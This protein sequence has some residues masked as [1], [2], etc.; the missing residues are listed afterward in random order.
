[1]EGRGLAE[2]ATVGLRERQKQQRR[3]AIMESARSLFERVGIEDCSM[4]MIAAE[5][6]VSTPTVF[7]YF[8]SRDEL[9]LALIF[10]G[11]QAAVDHYRKDMQHRTD[12]LAD[13]VCTLLADLTRRSAEIFSK[14]VWRYAESTAIRHPQSEFV[15]R[16]G[17]IDQILARTIG[18]VLADHGCRT[19]RPGGY[20]VDVLAS[21]I[22]SH[23]F[24]HYLACI[25]DEEMSL[26]TQLARMLPEIRLL[27]DL[28]FEDA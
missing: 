12:S 21:I 5:A 2:K 11:H 27:L 18:E 23:W 17:Q 7:N 1:M 24:N 25:K 16:F 26:E 13:D 22:Y 10:D 6:G 4:A 14:A 8:G 9:L 20:D 3:E 28:I 15:Q 19:R